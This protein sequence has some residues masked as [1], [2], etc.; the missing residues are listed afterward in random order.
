M[1]FTLITGASGGIGEVFARKLAAEG[2]NLVL[3]ARSEEKLR[4]LCDELKAAHGISAYFV[5]IDLT[6]F[7]AD[8]R[9]FEE[10]ER[11][12]IE[13][14][15]LINN[16]GFGSKGDFVDL[17]LEREL[18][19]ISLNVMSLTALTHRYLTKMR[20]RGRGTIINVSSAASFQPV[21]YMA[22]YA[23]TKA[24]VTSF[25]E[26][27]AEE[28]SRFGIHVMALCPGSTRTNFFRAA[29]IDR[30]IHPKGQQT[31]EEVVDEALAA[32]AKGRRKIVSGWT[33]YILASATNFV[34]NFLITRA[35]AKAFRPPENDGE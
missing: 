22:T 18:D 19:M 6:D 34:P 13:I 30:P 25:S 21:P 2:Q 3:V 15:W 29:N 32:L 9:L 5:A 17:D 28:N 26:A 11:Q 27:L 16:A 23:A 8:K 1:K 12:S 35:V 7:E 4:L 24:F 10:T 14:D 31:P 33:N 20:E